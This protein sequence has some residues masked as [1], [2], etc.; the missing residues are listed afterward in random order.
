MATGVES[1]L[2]TSKDWL[3]L[4][5]KWDEEEVLQPIIGFIQHSATPDY[6]TN[7][8]MLESINYVSVALNPGKN[9]GSKVLTRSPSILMVDLQQLS[10]PSHRARL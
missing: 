5:A 8:A 7:N 3:Q 9:I 6:I 10:L 2:V 4:Q 1:V